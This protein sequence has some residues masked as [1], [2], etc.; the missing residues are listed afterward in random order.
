MNGRAVV[1][2]LDGTLVDTAPDLTHATN[3]VLAARGRKPVSPADVRAMVGLGARAL[4]RRGFA[5]TGQPVAEEDIEDLFALFLAYYARNIAIDSRLFPG[6]KELLDLLSERGL[7]LGICTNKPEAL[8]RALIDSLG[9]SQYFGAVVGMDTISVAKPDP[10]IYGETLRQLRIDGGKTVMIG[11]SETD[12][13]T[14]RAAGVP[15]IGVSFGYGL[16]PVDEFDPDYVAD[17]FG[18][19]W[20][21][22]ERALDS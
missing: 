17:S 7:R 22:I 11:D 1:F 21:L 15:V 5:A 8:S 10:R 18:E 2:D 4:I 14:A 9:V 19:L 20:P 13:L 6:S 12:V 16:K 3:H